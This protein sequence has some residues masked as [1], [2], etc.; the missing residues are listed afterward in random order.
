MPATVAVVALLRNQIYQIWRF[1]AL[2]V[3][4]SRHLKDVKEFRLAGPSVVNILNVKHNILSR[5]LRH[6]MAVLLP[7][8]G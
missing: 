6:R 4:T 3:E 7:S 8:F 1:R 2:F 5:L